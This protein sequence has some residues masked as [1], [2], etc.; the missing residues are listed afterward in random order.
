MG[1]PRCLACL[2]DE[3]GETAGDAFVLG[4]IL[5]GSVH[6]ALCTRHFAG[7]RDSPA[8]AKKQLGVEEKPDAS[9]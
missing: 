5:S 3:R 6:G 9:R 2:A 1:R 4:L 8:K 7:A